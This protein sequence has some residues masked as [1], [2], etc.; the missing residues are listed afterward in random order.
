MTP[1]SPTTPTHPAPL[2]QR[3]LLLG[4]S[5]LLVFLTLGIVLEALHGF[6][7]GWY[8]AAH[9]EVRRLMWTLAHA[10]GVLLG[11][12][13]IAF[14]TTLS[15]L[16]ASDTRWAQRASPLLTGASIL[17]PSGFFLGGIILHDGDPSLGIVLTPIGALLLLMATALTVYGLMHRR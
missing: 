6:K 7:V 11:L 5:C 12:V 1:D 8:L 13:H 9:H 16:Q 14:A 3:H 17:L 4:W 10:H 2:P 15:T